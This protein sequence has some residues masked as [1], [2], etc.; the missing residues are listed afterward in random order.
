MPEKVPV[1]R[2]ASVPNRQA[3]RPAAHAIS[4]STWDQGRLC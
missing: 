2:S 3:Y 4:A 1:E